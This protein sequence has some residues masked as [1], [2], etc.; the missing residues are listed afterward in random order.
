MKKLLFVL[1][2]G[3]LAVGLVGCGDEVEKNKPA[4]EGEPV[5]KGE[6]DEGKVDGEEKGIWQGGIE[7]SLSMMSS[8]DEGLESG[9]LKFIYKLK[10]QT[11][12]EK[13]FTFTSGQMYDYKIYDTDGE[14]VFH[15]S[16]VA[17]FIQ[18][19]QTKTL[20]QGQKF[21]FELVID[22][23]LKSGNYRI[24]AWLTAKDEEDYKVSQKFTVK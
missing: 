20:K 24:E 1:F 2:I 17:S 15:F 16:K 18:S 13:E 19:I 11:E 23:K 10:N 12:K 22:K 6:G 8:E 4:S 3:L 21:D 7:P 14:E 9:M 5:T